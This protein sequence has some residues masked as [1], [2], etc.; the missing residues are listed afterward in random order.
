VHLL[1]QPDRPEPELDPIIMRRRAL[2]A[3]ALGLG[4]ATSVVLPDWAEAAARTADPDHT[5]GRG[6][7]KDSF[8]AARHELDYLGA[9]YVT[10]PGMTKHSEVRDSGLW[11]YA[12]AKQLVKSAPP[13]YRGEAQRLTAEA[14]AF[15]AG[16]YLDFGHMKAAMD[17]YHHAHQACGND[18]ADLREFIACQAIWVPMYSNRWQIVLNRA[19]SATM[20]A[21]KHG[22][23]SLLMAHTLHAAAQA[24]YGDKAGARESLARA[25]D[26]IDRVPGARAPHTALGYS[27]TK[28]WFSSANSYAM[29]GDADRQHEA[30]HRAMEDPTLGW[31]DRQ[32]MRLGQATLDPDPEHAAHRIRFQLLSIPADGFAHCVKT[33]AEKALV[34]LK[35][36]QITRTAHGRQA[37][38][39]VT[40]LGQYLRTVKV[41]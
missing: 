2:L 19:Q 6:T 36:R 9:H 10:E 29:I 8:L 35:A 21:E 18:H 38:S 5:T 17:L 31:M 24:A 33:D 39:E 34:R 12:Q 23:Y 22:G 13:G 30:Q 41:A 7:W 25:Q 28:V 37:G 16:C 15:A 14:A 11:L 20:S 3:A 1:I 32:L 4:T 27:A 40:M 26:N